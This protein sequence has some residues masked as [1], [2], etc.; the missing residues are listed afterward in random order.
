MKPVLFLDF[1][2]TLFDTDQFYDWLGE[3][4]FERILA[5]TGGHI[6]PPDFAAYLYPDTMHFLKNIRK[7]YRVVILTYALNTLLQRKKLRGSGIIPFCDDVLIAQGG[8]GEMTGKGE[9]AK[10]YLARVGDSGWEH[11]F[12][13]D[14][15]MNI[16]EVKRANPDMRCIRIDRA[17]LKK[18]LLHDAHMKPD[19]IVT[20]L[21]ELEALL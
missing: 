1:D 12:V 6:D 13:D 9:I 7:T 8:E 11:V 3:D 16:D 10:D 4:R 18:G 19:A 14:A 5:L 17:P 21:T 15:P 2:R 20:N